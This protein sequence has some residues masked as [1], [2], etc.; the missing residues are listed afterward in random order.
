MTAVIDTRSKA[1]FDGI[2]NLEPILVRKV[3]WD[4]RNFTF[5]GKMTCLSPRDEILN[6]STASEKS[7]VCLEHR[8]FSTTDNNIK[9]QVEKKIRIPATPFLP[10]GQLIFFFLYY[11]LPYHLH[12]RTFFLIWSLS[13]SQTK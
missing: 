9:S 5:V 4:E 3:T 7:H 8:I 12:S 13:P 6:S 11:L 10:F 2:L 1:E